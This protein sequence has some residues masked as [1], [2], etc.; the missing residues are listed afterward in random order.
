MY[1]VLILVFFI[2]LPG[3]TQSELVQFNFLRNFRCSAEG[4]VTLLR[5][6][7]TLYIVIS[8]CVVF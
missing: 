6:W 8:N 7:S 3:F 2:A 4:A 5:L 1:S